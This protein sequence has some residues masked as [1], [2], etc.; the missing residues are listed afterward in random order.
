[1]K[2]KVWGLCLT[3]IEINPRH[4]EK[5]GEVNSV[6]KFSYL[7]PYN[8]EL[9]AHERE[10]PFDIYGVARYYKTSNN[11]LNIFFA[12]LD[13]KCDELEIESLGINVSKDFEKDITKLESQIKKGEYK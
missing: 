4:K 2:S 1:M 5:K 7:L 3:K 11:L 9:N 12:L 10:I 6:L 8:G 13:H